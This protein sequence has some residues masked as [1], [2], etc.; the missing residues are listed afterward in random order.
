MI[1]CLSA[2]ALEAE[3]DPSQ[4]HQK[5]LQYDKVIRTV[6]CRVYMVTW[7]NELCVWRLNNPVTFTIEEF[8]NC[9]S[10]TRLW[11]NV[12]QCGVA[13]ITA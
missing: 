8:Y 4:K 3:R 6:P 5:S 13:S 9:Y 1:Q 7:G 12:I 2:A 11:H 10:L